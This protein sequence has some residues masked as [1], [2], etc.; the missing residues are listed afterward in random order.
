MGNV[1]MNNNYQCSV[2]NYKPAIQL[3]DNQ[4]IADGWSLTAENSIFKRS[5]QYN[6]KEHTEVLFDNSRLLKALVS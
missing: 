2:L 4:P 5:E 1:I 6:L 3:I